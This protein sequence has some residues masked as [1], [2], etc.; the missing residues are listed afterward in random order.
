MS[1]ERRRV[2][3]LTHPNFLASILFCR[4]SASLLTLAPPRTQPSRRCR[5]LYNKMRGIVRRLQAFIA[6]FSGFSAE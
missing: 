5:R 2:L 3:R 4:S 1:A 6:G